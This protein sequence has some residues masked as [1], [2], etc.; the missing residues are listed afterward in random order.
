MVVNHEVLVD[1]HLPS[2]FALRRCLH[3]EGAAGNRHVCG[4]LGLVLMQ[5]VTEAAG[6]GGW[7]TVPHGTGGERAWSLTGEGIR[8]G[9]RTRDA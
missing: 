5:I 7:E 3:H 4:V 2:E 8:A 9:A 6:S 1:G